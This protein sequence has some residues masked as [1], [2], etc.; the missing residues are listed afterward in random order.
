MY[1][2]DVFL[3]TVL[4]LIKDKKLSINQ[5]EI[6]AGLGKGTIYNWLYKS[7]KPNIISLIKL[8]KF[9][10]VSIDYLVFGD[11]GE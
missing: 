11:K 4:K 3:D 9:F 1:C 7:G 2:V 5:T 10:N 8:S 6:R